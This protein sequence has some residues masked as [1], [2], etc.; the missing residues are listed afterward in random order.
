MKQISSLRDIGIG[1]TT[2]ILVNCGT[3]WPTTLALAS[4][5]AHTDWPVVVIDCESTD[6]SRGHFARLAACHGLRFGW[7]EWPLRSHAETLDAIFTS[8]TAP[9]VLLM[10]SDAEIADRR[11]AD[12]MQAALD[13]DANAYGAGFL[14]GPAWLGA[15]HGLPP[16][17]GYYAQRMWVPLVL[18]RTLAV[19]RALDQGVSFAQERI[20]TELPNAPRLSRW[21]ACRFWLPGLRRMR[22]LPLLPGD[23]RRNRAPAFVEHDTGARMHAALQAQGHAFAAIDVRLWGDVRHL[24]GVTRAKLAARL[25]TAARRAGLLKADNATAEEAVLS[26][27]KQRLAQQYAITADFAG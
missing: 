5:V 13:A 20:F 10:D 3:K 17:V 11:V 15:P 16:D 25:R 27:V 23:E 14:H 19:R 22:S 18:L 24:H 2:T 8:I 6:G 26:Q 4:A 7:L 1:S 9:A 12:A 21:L